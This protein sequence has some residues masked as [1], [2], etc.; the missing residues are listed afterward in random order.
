MTQEQL[1]EA[2]DTTDI[3]KEVCTLL[4]GVPLETKIK[5]LNYAKDMKMLSDLS[6]KR[7]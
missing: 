2:G 4:R 3:S 5:I 1:A 6:P 7:G